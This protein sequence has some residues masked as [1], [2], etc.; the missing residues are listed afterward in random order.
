MKFTKYLRS[1]TFTEMPLN[2]NDRTR[3]FAFVTALYHARDKLL[4]LNNIHFRETNFVIEAAR[5][6]V[7]IAKTIVKSN[8]SIRPQVVVNR[9]P[10]NQDVFSRPK[11][12]P[13]ELFYTNAAK[14]ARLNSG[15]QAA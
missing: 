11:L 4:K 1:N 14:S 13:G 15:K 2:L 8:H 5:C 12:V 6:E 3:G 10:E 7:K 9:F